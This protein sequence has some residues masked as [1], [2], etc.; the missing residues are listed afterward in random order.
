MLSRKNRARRAAVFNVTYFGA[1]P[2][3]S[4]RLAEPASTIAHVESPD[5]DL[6]DSVERVIQ[7]RSGWIAI[8][9]KE[10]FAYRDLLFHLVWRDV[11]VR[12]K[13]TVLG[14][15]WAVLQPLILMLIF[16]FFGAL[17]RSTPRASLTLY[18]SLPA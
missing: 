13:Q 10:M 9:W 16:T 3:T 12:Y 2:I 14:P 7:P 1:P 11:T 8:D 18:L 6:A 5:G 15:A 17:A 4:S